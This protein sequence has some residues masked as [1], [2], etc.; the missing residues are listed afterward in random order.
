MTLR[1]ATFLSV[2]IPCRHTSNLIRAGFLLPRRD[3]GREEAYW[4]SMPQVNV[5]CGFDAI[6]GVGLAI[7]ACPFV[8]FCEAGLL[9]R[10]GVGTQLKL[11]GRLAGNMH[12][13]H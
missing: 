9:M 8:Q 7:F 11:Y 6:A 2:H 5:C 13:R 4:F 12:P 3:V 10:A 1:D